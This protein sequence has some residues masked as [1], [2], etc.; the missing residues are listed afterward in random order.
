MFDSCSTPRPG[1][2]ESP[3]IRVDQPRKGRPEIAIREQAAGQ[4]VR[5][6]RYH[7]II[8]RVAWDRTRE[9]FRLLREAESSEQILWKVADDI[10]LLCTKISDGYLK[11]ATRI[12]AV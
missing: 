4:L 2:S 9:L 1:C 11:A 10:S 6:R 5:A 12:Y 3:L 7:L 8:S